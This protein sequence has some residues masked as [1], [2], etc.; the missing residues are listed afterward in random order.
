MPS[1]NHE[2]NVISFA[3][4]RITQGCQKPPLSL[5][6]NALP[7]EAK[8]LMSFL[9][10]VEQCFIHQTYPNTSKGQLHISVTSLTGTFGG[11]SASH[12]IKV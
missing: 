8:H 7:M 1:F 9:N 4:L 6:C 5:D 3:K 10:N 2:F 12:D 11:W